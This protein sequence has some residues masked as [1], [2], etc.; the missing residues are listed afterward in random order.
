MVAVIGA[1][2]D[3]RLIAVNQGH[4]GGIDFPGQ[5]RGVFY[6]EPDLENCVCA[7]E[8]VLSILGLCISLT[9]GSE[10]EQGVY[11]T[12]LVVIGGCFNSH[13][14]HTFL[15]HFSDYSVIF[16]QKLMTEIK[17]QNFC[18]L[19]HFFKNPF[20]SCFFFSI[21]PCHQFLFSPFIFCH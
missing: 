18:T 19:F 14:P 2:L 21:S 10:Q 11:H 6:P 8:E 7:L 20:I 13:S 1:V 4:I 16:T 9:L 17:Q 12:I 5:A 3:F 15:H